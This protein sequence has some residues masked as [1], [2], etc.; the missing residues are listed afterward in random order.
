[1]TI[2]KCEQCNKDFEANRETA[3]FCSSKCKLAYHR[4][5]VSVSNNDKVSVSS[6]NK[7]SVSSEKVHGREAVSYGKEVNEFGMEWTTRPNPDDETDVPV[8]GLLKEIGGCLK[9]KINQFI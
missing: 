3:R 1:M 8:K 9:E 4:N 5:K 2:K 7:V 6:E